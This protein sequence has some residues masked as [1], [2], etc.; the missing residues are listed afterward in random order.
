[1]RWPGPPRDRGVGPISPKER[2]RM[3]LCRANLCLPL[4]LL[5]GPA[6]LAAA[7][8]DLPP[9]QFFIVQDQ[10]P[11]TGCVIGTDPTVYRGQ[12]V[13]DVR[14]VSAA[15]DTGYAVFPLV[16][17]DLPAP[18]ADET[19]TNRIQLVGFD[20]DIE[21]LGVEPPGTDALLRSLAGGDLVHF[22]M[23]WSGVI[24][25]GGGVKSATV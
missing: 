24:D 16:K 10:V 4:S 15:T 2:A 21:P 23:P 7:G 13:M 9:H 12:G 3:T 5:L 1:M 18:A 19:A 25:P 17:N 8:C 14:L 20:V 6:L 11:Q 22:R